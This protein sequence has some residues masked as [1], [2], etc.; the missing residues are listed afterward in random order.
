MKIIL[1]L[2]ILLAAIVFAFQA[3]KK[4]QES[5]DNARNPAEKTKIV[6]QIATLPLRKPLPS[7]HGGKKIRSVS[8]FG[9]YVEDGISE[10]YIRYNKLSASERE[11]FGFPPPS[12]SDF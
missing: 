4:N 8:K 7:I 10:E 2:T 3:S 12:N 1:I 5:T 6:E 9:I 11:A